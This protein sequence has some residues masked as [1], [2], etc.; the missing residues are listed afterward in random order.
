MRWNHRTRSSHRGNPLFAQPQQGSWILRHPRW[1]LFIVVCLFGA[2]MYGV[3][4]APMWQLQ[5]AEIQG[6]YTLPLDQ[7]RTEIVDQTKARWLLFFRQDGIWS[8]DTKALERRLRSRWIFTALSIQR[9]PLHRIRISM[10]EELPTFLLQQNAVTYGI[11]RQGV[12][13]AM[14]DATKLKN[15]PTLAPAQVPN[16]LGLN[17][18]IL[19]QTDAAFLQH[20]STGMRERDG[21]VLAV[22]SILLPEA[23]DRTAQL[24]VPAGWSVIVD[25]SGDPQKQLAAFLLAYEQKLIGKSLEYVNVTVPSRVYYK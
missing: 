2:A 4:G 12:L 24:T 25:R 20:M 19:S 9:R 13:S 17:M 21:K 14:V 1:A 11:N 3:Y 23:P 5:H 18:E 15:V 6:N 22:Q 8:F 16:P 10:Q 7:L